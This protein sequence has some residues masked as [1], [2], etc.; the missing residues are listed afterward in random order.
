MYNLY[1]A[2]E[3]FMILI[4]VNQNI[5]NITNANV[6]EIKNNKIGIYYDSEKTLM[7]NDAEE[8]DTSSFSE[9]FMKFIRDD[10]TVYLNKYH[11]L[12]FEKLNESTI[13]FHFFENFSYDIQT[14]F[15]TLVNQI[16]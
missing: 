8:L 15:E 1:R 16:E 7:I 10:L 11:F 14:D 12:Y 3:N 13:R 4:E 6:I 9:Y 2:M 5:F